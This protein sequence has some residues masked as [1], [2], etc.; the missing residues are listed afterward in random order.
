MSHGQ[1]HVSRS[2][3]ASGASHLQGFE[4][5]E[6]AN[7][8]RHRLKRQS[9]TTQDLEPPCSDARSD[10]VEVVPRT[11]VGGIA[12]ASRGHLKHAP[13]HHHHRH[14]CPHEHHSTAA[15]SPHL[16]AV[17]R[18]P[19]LL[20]YSTSSSLAIARLVGER[21]LELGTFKEPMDYARRRR[22]RLSGPIFVHT[23]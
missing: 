20:R 3:T 16:E 1:R 13:N 10:R 9:I 7:R 19:S 2:A 17:S 22:T 5:I 14:G 15:P 8:R 12:R 21:R 18:L 4:L 11:E 6:V 23:Y